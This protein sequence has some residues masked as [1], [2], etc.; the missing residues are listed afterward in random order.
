MNPKVSIVIPVFNAEATLR[1]TVESL[2]YGTE[3]D[4]EI[5]LVDDC[6]KDSSWKYCQDL[7]N[8]YSNIYCYQNMSN[9]GVS[10]TRNFGLEKAKS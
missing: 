9:R 5:I 10:Y 2:I 7:S 4:I 8:K 6:S 1:R 3:R